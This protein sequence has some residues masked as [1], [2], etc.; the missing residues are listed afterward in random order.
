[1]NPI[2]DIACVVINIVLIVVR[3]PVLLVL[4]IILSVQDAL[5]LIPIV[6]HLIIIRSVR[7]LVCWLILVSVGIVS[8]FSAKR[9]DFRKLQVKRPD[10]KARSCA[11]TVSTFHG[12]IDVLVHAVASKPDFFVFAALDGTRIQSRTIIGA[13][14]VALKAPIASSY[15]Q[16]SHIPENSVLFLSPSPTNGLGL[17]RMDTTAISSALSGL[18]IQICALNYACV[19]RYYPHHLT[20]STFSHVMKL[21]LFNWYSSV[22]VSILPEPLQFESVEDVPKLKTLMARLSA[23]AAVETDIDPRMYLEFL[24]YWRETQ[25]R[26]Y[27]VIK[28]RR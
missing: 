15:D 23:P 11:C 19:G 12:F 17:L 21:S 14:S 4:G 9:E 28:M 13:I 16:T 25:S 5:S 6:S 22:G 8:P 2:T 18:P 24:A 3:L 10:G 27:G 1:M 7:P 20:E 26:D